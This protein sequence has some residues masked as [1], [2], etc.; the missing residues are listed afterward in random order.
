MTTIIFDS[1]VFTQGS[2]SPGDRVRHQSGPI[3]TG[4][5]SADKR[6]DHAPTAHAP[7]IAVTGMAT[8]TLPTPA[9]GKE[10]AEGSVTAS[11]RVSTGRIANALARSKRQP[12]VGGRHAMV[13]IKDALQAT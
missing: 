5:K 9:Q 4:D 7:R 1:A 8:G 11:V 3:G 2:R 6:I 12:S 13:R 10:L